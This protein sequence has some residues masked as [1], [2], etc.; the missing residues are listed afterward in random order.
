M[1]VAK[2]WCSQCR[3]SQLRSL[4]RELE[5]TRIREDQ[6]SRVPPLR[7]STAKKRPERRKSEPSTHRLLR[8]KPSKI[9]HLASD[10][11]LWT[12]PVGAQPALSVFSEGLGLVCVSLLWFN[13][14]E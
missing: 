8:T 5:L 11:R 12:C 4:V 2:T 3:E 9:P 13:A 6:R 14:P 1:V 7:P 10:H